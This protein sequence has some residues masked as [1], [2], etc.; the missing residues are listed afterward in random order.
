MDQSLSGGRGQVSVLSCFPPSVGRDIAVAVVKPLGAGL[1]NPGT[2]SLLC[3][4]KQVKW[5]MEVLCYGLTLPLEG[6][7]VKLCVDIYTDW[8]MALVSPRDST[9]PPISRDPNLYVQKIL[10]HLFNLFS[11]RSDQVNLV[12]LSLYQQVLCAVQVLAKEST[13]MSRDTWETLLHFLL[14][15]NH[16]ML[17]PATA[18]GGVSDMLMAVLLE[19][20]LLSCSR[21]FPSRSLW[22]TCRQMLSSWRHQPAVV[23]QWCRVVAALTS[24]LLQLTFGPSFPHFKVPEEDA[25]LIPEDMDDKRIPQTWFRFLHLFSNPVELS[26]TAAVVPSQVSQGEVLRR[27]D[28]QLPNIFFKAMSGVGILVDAF[29]GVTVENKETIEQLLPNTG[30]TTKLHFRDRLPSFG[31]SVTKSPFRDRLPSY[32][33]SRPRSGSAP[34]TPVN[35]LSMPSSSSS[36]SS[37]PPYNR[38]V[39]AANFSKTTTKTPTIPSSHWKSFSQLP[40]FSSLFCSSLR[41]SPSPLRCNVDHLLHLF[42]CWL[43]DAAL[44]SRD[45]AGQDDVAVMSN[46][47]AAGRAEACGTLCR[48]FSCRKTAEE[49][50]SVYLSR[51]YLVLIQGLQV[52]EKASSPVLASIL[53]NSTSLFCCDLRGVNILLPPFISALENVLLD[54][55]LLK[56]KNFVTP[57]D[58]RRASILV[59]LS[60]LPIPMHFGSVQLEELQDR[61]LSADAATGT[62]LLLKPRLISV[63]IG[64]LQTEADTC[65]IQLLLAAM[66]NLIQDSA[67]L[68]PA[69][70]TQQE[71]EPLL[72]G[73]SKLKQA[74]GASQTSSNQWT[75]GSNAVA[76][77]WVQSLRLLTQRLTSQWRN[78]SAVCLSALEVL[79]GLAKVEVRVEESERMRV[80]SSVC[81]CIVFQCSR[82]PPLHSRDLHSIIVAAFQC[83]SVWLTQHPT[84]LGHKECLLEVLEIVELGISGSKSRQEQKVRCKEEKDQNPASL[85]VKEAAEATLSCVMQVSEAF[86]FVS[87]ILNEDVLVRS[88]CQ[89]D[90]SLEKFRYF[91]VESSTILAFLEQTLGREQAQYPSLIMVTRGASGC[92]TWSL[93]L[94]PKPHEGQADTQE[95]LIPEQHSMAQEDARIQTVIKQQLLSE[96]FDTVP[97]VKADHSIP[98]L[99]ETITEEVQQQLQ[100]LRTALKRQQQ[101]E[102]RPQ[103]SSRSAVPMT[104]KPPPPVIHFQAARLFLS[105]LGLLTPES[106]KDPGISGVPAPLVVLDSSLPGFFDSLRNLDQQPSRIYDSTFIFYMGAGQRTEA[107]ILKNVESA[108]NVHSHFLD[109]LSSLGWPVE[110]GQVGRVSTSRSEFSS[111]LGDSGG[112]VFDGKRFILMSTDSLTELTFIVPSLLHSH[113]GSSKS[114][115]VLFPP[116]ESPLNLP[117]H[118]KSNSYPAMMPCNSSECNSMI[119][120]VE[121]FEDIEN[122]PVSGLLSHTRSQTEMSISTIQLIFIHPLK[123]GLYRIHVSENTTSKFGLVVPLVSGSV[124]SKRSLGFLVREMVINWCHRRLLESDSTPPPHIRRKHMIND[125]TLRYRSRHSEPAFY[126]SLFYEP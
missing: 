123:T 2:R 124:V 75:R 72:T 113:D 98:A 26:R 4:D 46:G 83:L 51:F 33:I 38:Q 31:I 62:L 81:T 24:R 104:C 65:N 108:C 105:H 112:S 15:I 116:A 88:S 63:L 73:T 85:R 16:A 13:M 122:F 80:V 43:F 57:V 89:S 96:S 52:S 56:F 18:A 90:S 107:E 28:S 92:H 47:W 19:V 99:H 126:S 32:G 68:E 7:T 100:H 54:R 53:L 34:P 23:E 82:P 97:S 84:L 22:Q 20:W 3:T 95:P 6:D 91:V 115:E 42:G 17:S 41:P 1:G 101:V 86:P 40:S 25:A 121:R 49:I 55:E 120:W 111:V 93:E 36:T 66:L 21:C 76:V 48:I 11:P 117:H 9:P 110:V 109:F 106:V 35:V 70:R 27:G 79:G 39:T 69:G 77:L 14:R 64:A 74:L 5:T 10:R 125:I 45:S 118:S 12:Y 114:S 58:L 71:T 67:V 29:L 94:C 60:L 61:K 44:I 8:L 102:A 50:L 59:L 30:M 87:G 103:A 119:V 37:S 78:D